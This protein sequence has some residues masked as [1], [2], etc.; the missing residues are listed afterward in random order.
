MATGSRAA[1]DLYVISGRLGGTISSASRRLR[2]KSER[3][4]VE[5][6][7][8][9][10]GIRGPR[11]SVAERRRIAGLFTVTHGLFP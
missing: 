7:D 6:P 2:R 1:G 4:I 5:L 8:L 9:V 3:F 10:D 11:M